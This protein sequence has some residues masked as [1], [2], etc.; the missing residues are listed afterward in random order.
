MNNCSPNQSTKNPSPAFREQRAIDWGGTK[1]QV[2]AYWKGTPFPAPLVYDKLSDFKGDKATWS[3]SLIRGCKAGIT[4]REQ[5]KRNEAQMNAW[6]A[7]VKSS[8]KENASHGDRVAQLLVCAKRLF[9]DIFPDEDANQLL[10]KWRTLW[11]QNI[12]CLLKTKVISDSEMFGWAISGPAHLLKSLSPDGKIG[13]CEM[14]Q[15]D[16]DPTDQDTLPEGISTHPTGLNPS[17]YADEMVK[18]GRLPRHE[19]RR[20]ERA[21]RK[22]AGEK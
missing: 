9:G 11:A 7:D 17:E 3:H 19:R 16:H 22:H 10:D 5:N 18:Q 12:M 20:L 8:Y 2:T 21:L 14:I 13:G 6:E 1:I 4:L 15:C